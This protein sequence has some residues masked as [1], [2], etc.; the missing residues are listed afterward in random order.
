MKKLIGFILILTFILSMSTVTFA[1]GGLKCSGIS[2]KDGVGNTVTALTQE[3]VCA[4]VS[5]TNLGSSSVKPVLVVTSYQDNKLNALWY[6]AADAQIGNGETGEISVTF[7]PVTVENTVI[8][9]TVV[10]SMLK[11]NAPVAAAKM[12]ESSTSVEKIM[13]GDIFVEGC[14]DEEDSYMVKVSGS[15]ALIKAEATDGG[16]MVE[17]T[18]PKK[19][20]GKGKISLTSPSGETRDIDV[21]VYNKDE[22][23][24]SLASLGYEIDGV[25]YEVEG[26]EPEKTEY[27]VTL[28]DNTFY[29]TLVGET[30]GGAVME[31]QIED[32]N[33]MGVSYG[34]VSYFLGTSYSGPKGKRAAVNNL[35]PVKNEQTDA[36]ITVST[37]TDARSYKVSFKAKQP[38]LTE[39]ALGSGS[40]QET[41]K[42]YFISG[43]AL[44]NDNGTILGVDRPTWTLVGITKPLLG[45]SMISLSSINSARSAESWQ[46]TNTTG[47][48]CS[49][50]ADTAG[51]IYMMCATGITNTDYYSEANGW[52]KIT[53][54][55]GSYTVPKNGLPITLNEESEAIYLANQQWSD[56]LEF[57]TL[58]GIFSPTKMGAT[59]NYNNV[60]VKSFDAGELVSIHHPG[61]TTASGCA[62]AVIIWDLD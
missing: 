36:H 35:V 10:G 58:Q 31:T 34:G 50:K 29:V 1:E 51:T 27:T 8:E 17:V 13:V 62:E 42:P 52:T 32:I 57:F 61:A 6:K 48:W 60:M 41:E 23:L 46:K 53:N 18:Q 49:F 54:A 21:T 45:G 12:L 16:T 26:F 2:F 59:Q 15:E 39:F 28:P 44:N 22:Q 20:P 4:S 24:Y 9:A 55:S 43:A 38:R 47:E 40:Y 5:V 7:T 3:P 33:H 11:L 37:E 14:S 30:L 25:Y 56:Q 19:V